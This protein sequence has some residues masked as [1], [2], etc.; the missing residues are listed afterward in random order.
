MLAGLKTDE[1]TSL[2]TIEELQ[3][4]SQKPVTYE[5]GLT[6]AQELGAVCYAECSAKQGAGLGDVFG[7]A[8]RVG[9]HYKGLR[10]RESKE[11]KCV[12]M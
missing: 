1:R 11:K 7:T 4:T 5:D 3:K 12:V 10:S 8:A 2:Q 9:W 6:V